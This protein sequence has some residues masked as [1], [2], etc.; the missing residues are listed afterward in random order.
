M[1]SALRDIEQMQATIAEQGNKVRAFKAA[2]ADKEQIQNEVALLLKLKEDLKAMQGSTS[3]ENG[4]ASAAAGPS[5]GPGAGAGAGADVKS[6]HAKED[7]DDTKKF[8]LKTPKGT[9]DFLPEEMTIREQMFATITA[10]FQK[11][12]GVTIETPVFELK[13]ILAGKYGEDSKLI[14]DLQDQGGELASLRYDLTVP[15]AR[16]LAMRDISQMKR[17]HIAKVYRRDNPSVAKGRMREFYQ[18]DFDIAGE[19]EPMVADSEAVKIMVELLT[20]LGVGAFTIKI[21]NRRILDA[22]FAVCGVPACM[23]RAIS[24]SVDKLDKMAWPDVKHEM[25]SEKGL[26]A[27]VADRI[28]TYTALK[29]TSVHVLAALK[30]DAEFMANDSARTGVAEM[31]LLFKYLALYGVE[32]YVAFD[33]SLARGLDYYTGVIYEAVL[34]DEAEET[35]G[36]GSIA[37]GGRYDDLVGMFAPSGKK[38]PCVGVSI[39]VER[40]FSILMKKVDKSRLRSAKTEVYVM[41]MGK[42]GLLEERM[43]LAKELWEADI[44][45]EFMYK[46]KPRRDAQFAVVDREGIPYGVF[47]GSS[48]LQQGIV[49]DG[50]GIEKKTRQIL[51]PWP[52]GISFVLLHCD[53]YKDLQYK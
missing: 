43:R 17:Y 44:K 20:A 27:D 33:L 13:E 38:I 47:I 46:A 1:S 45:T 12:G 34:C 51:G 10:I 24:S 23:F 35:Q 7:D 42:D 2:K 52:D 25:C 31:E 50:R 41:A 36:I 3:G 26:A 28:G 6:R 32:E 48:E 11:H 16:F 8:T 40:V 9:R 30:A 22:L 15:F 4:R 14:Y 19:H 53:V 29:G 18:C 49:S 5:A 21:N 39:G 37:A